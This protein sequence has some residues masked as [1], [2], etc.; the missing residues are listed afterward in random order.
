MVYS[1]VPLFS[2]VTSKYVVVGYEQD[3]ILSDTDLNHIL[4]QKQNHNLLMFYVYFENKSQ[5]IDKAFETLYY[6]KTLSITNICWIQI[7]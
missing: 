7:I 2:S 5:L 3:I 6:F 4:I 1:S